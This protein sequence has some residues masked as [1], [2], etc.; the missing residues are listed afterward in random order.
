MKNETLNDHMFRLS[1]KAI[2]RNDK[3]EILVVK[4]K[5]SQWTLPGGGLDHNEDL[6]VGLSRELREEVAFEGGFEAEVVAV[7]EPMWL[8]NK[9]IWQV[10]IVYNV[11]PESHTFAKGPDADEIAFMDPNLFK[12][13]PHRS[14]Q[15]IYKYS[16]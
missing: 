4:E 10:W 8:S 2:I 13:S 12:D 11:K 7:S 15:L 5:G 16:T 3:N 9:L 6:M 14:E 1:L